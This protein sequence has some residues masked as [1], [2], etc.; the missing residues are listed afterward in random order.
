MK[1]KCQYFLT[2][3]LAT[4]TQK[5]YASAQQKFFSFCH[6]GG[7]SPPLPATEEVLCLFITQLSQSVQPQSIKVYLSAIRSLHISQGYQ[8]PLSN[9]PLLQLVLRGIK[10]TQS[11]VLQERLPITDTLMHVIYKSL[12]LNE[13]DHTMFWAACTLAYFG[14]L[15]ASEFTVPNLNTFDA[16]LHLQLPDV[17]FDC[18]D[19]PVCLRIHIKASKTDPFRQGCHIYIGRGTQHLCAVQAMAAYLNMR[20]N[21][22]GPLFLLSSGKPLSRHLL[23]S[24][25]QSIFS[26]ANHPGKFNTHSFR[27]GAA[28]VAARNGVPD[29]VIK[30]LGRW[31]SDSYTLYTRTSPESLAKISRLLS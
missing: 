26:K 4:T 30:V 29:H 31:A 9:R 16:Q 22:A 7:I 3:S 2:N 25:L 1:E 10:R 19:Q 23:S 21:N 15:R 5:T 6:N 12:N 20:G 27:I 11:P 28:T 8:D 14:F 17:S 13:H 24:W 18:H